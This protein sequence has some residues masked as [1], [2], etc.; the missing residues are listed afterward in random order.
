MTLLSL[1]VETDFVVKKVRAS[2]GKEKLNI[3]SHWGR[4]RREKEGQV[5]NSH[6]EA[7]F[8]A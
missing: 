6:S 3:L 1:F 5:I 8:E 7:A 2:P 4:E